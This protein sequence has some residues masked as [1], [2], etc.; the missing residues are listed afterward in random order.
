MKFSINGKTHEL[1]GPL[2]LSG[3]IQDVCKNNPYVIA[4]LN[5]SI[6]HKDLWQGINVCEGDRIELVSFVGGG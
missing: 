3:L 2:P 5:G 6:I 4:E 1:T